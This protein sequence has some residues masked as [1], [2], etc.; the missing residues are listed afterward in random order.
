MYNTEEEYRDVVPEGIFMQYCDRKVFG[1]NCDRSD[2]SI[3]HQIL[4][5]PFYER[6]LYGESI[7]EPYHEDFDNITFDKL[8]LLIKRFIVRFIDTPFHYPKIA[9]IT[10]QILHRIPYEENNNVNT[11]NPS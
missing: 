4:G 5:T 9:H 1:Y 6:S 7:F 2:L 8:I 10:T 3:T 11:G